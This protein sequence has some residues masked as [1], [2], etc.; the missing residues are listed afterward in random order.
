[1]DNRRLDSIDAFR[2][3]AILGMMVGNFIAGVNWI[4]SW[5]KHA[6]DIGYTIADLGAPA[7]IFAIGLTYGISTR[8][9]LEKDGKWNMTKHFVVRY[10]AILGMGALFSAGQILMQVDN[11]TINWGVMQ[12]IGVAGLVTLTVI[13]L[14]YQLRFLIGLVLLS[15]YQFMLNRYWLA[16][17]LASPHG[18][19]YGSMAWASMLIL[20]TVIADLYFLENRGY[21][22]LVIAS[23]LA[24]LVAFT[25]SVLW[26]PISKNR[27]SASYVL[28]S[29][30]LS[31]FIF[32]L[33]DLVT[34]RFNLQ[35]HTLVI[36]G[37]NPLILYLLHLFLLAFLT[38]PDVPGWYQSAS[39]WLVLIQGIALLSAI[40]GMA[41]LLD[42]KRIYLSI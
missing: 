30:G 23:T 28:L 4:P 13:R 38:L 2:G 9:R 20:A 19:L 31:G 33:F 15:V 35:L 24:I 18:G 16:N 25:L 41:S 29:L 8:R 32:T 17:V 21:R 3:F 34:E 27:V 37:R 6:P 22:N 11:V 26:F 1:M 40:V 14:P 36:C 39:P 12:A 42:R 5:L 10:F 7:F